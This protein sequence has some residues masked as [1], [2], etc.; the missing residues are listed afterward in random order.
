MQQNGNNIM[1]KLKKVSQGRKSQ[2]SKL[3]YKNETVSV[4]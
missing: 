1:Q 2:D 4:N 3:I